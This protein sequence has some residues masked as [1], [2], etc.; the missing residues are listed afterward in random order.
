MP[1]PDEL[2]HD[3]FFDPPGGSWED[4]E[5]EGELVTT[6]GGPQSDDLAGHLAYST[7]MAQWLSVPKSRLLSFV[8]HSACSPQQALAMDRHLHW[9]E[10]EFN[11]FA[12]NRRGIIT[13]AQAIIKSIIRE[14]KRLMRPKKTAAI[15][16][17]KLRPRW[18]WPSGTTRRKTAR[19]S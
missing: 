8:R 18:N 15:T 19:G 4:F 16:R 11:C 3:D 5:T 6:S 12:R 14:P 10:W 17:K 2:E 1:N 7:L 13:A 9:F